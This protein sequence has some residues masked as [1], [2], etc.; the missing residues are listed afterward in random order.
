MTDAHVRTLERQVAQLQ[1]RLG[2]SSAANERLSS[3]LK[4]A[5]ERLIALREDLDR[6]S[7]PPLTFAVVLQ[8]H[9]AV[10]AQS[11]PLFDVLA[12]GR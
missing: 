10:D 7:S 2:E 8:R 12:A 4:S 6:V 11:G 3:T 9:E 5:K 1:Q